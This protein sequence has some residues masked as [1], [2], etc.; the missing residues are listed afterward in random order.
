MFS[1]DKK[2]STTLEILL[3]LLILSSIV[4]ILF[5]TLSTL[6]LNKDQ[7]EHYVLAIRELSNLNELFRVSANTHEK[8]IQSWQNEILKKGLFSRPLIQQINSQQWRVE[9]DWD[10]SIAVSNSPFCFSKNSIQKTCFSIV[11]YS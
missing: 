11:I 2:G 9:L 7:G 1:L 8:T 6:H 4:A 10:N 3:S 5:K